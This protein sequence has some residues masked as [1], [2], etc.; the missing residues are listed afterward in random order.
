MKPRVLALIAVVFWSTAA[1]AFKLTLSWMT[2]YQL[3]LLATAVSTVALWTM[4]LFRRKR[5]IEAGSW[6]NAIAKSA[7]RGLLNPFLYYL[8]LLEAYNELPAQIAMV[9]NYLWPVVLIILSAPLLKQRITLKMAAASGI[10]FCGIG[11]L[12]LGGNPV[13]GQLPLLAIGLALLSTVIWALF[14]IL[15]IRA[16]GDAVRNLAES[17]IFGLLYLVIYGVISGKIPSIRGL[18]IH[19]IIGSIY[20]GLFEMGIT[21]VIWYKALELSETTSEVGNLI[22]LTPFMAL[23]FI[24]SVVG[25]KIGLW[26]IAGL[27]LVISGIALQG[28]GKRSNV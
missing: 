12:A 11:V 25:E 24:G 27:L 7:V 26:T 20:I 2:P 19:G 13:G 23:V 14:W 28:M 15:N 4:I 9:I 3:V 10:S 1:S 5:F 21:F 6:R 8:V 22:Y 18:D 17:F 16:S